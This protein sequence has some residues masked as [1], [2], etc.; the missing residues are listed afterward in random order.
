MAT[1]RKLPSGKYQ[2]IVRVV[3][4]PPVS[5]TFYTIRE[6]STWARHTEGSIRAG[7]YHD[8]S[9]NISI[10]DLL[11]EYLASIEHLATHSKDKYIVPM[12][13]LHFKHQTI[14][15]IKPSH[16]RSYMDIQKASGYAPGTIRKNT[17]LLSRAL[18]YACKDLDI[19]FKNPMAHIRL[20]STKPMK[21]RRAITPEEEVRILAA[22]SDQMKDITIVAIETGLRRSEITKMKPE[23][24]DHQNHTLLVPDTKNGHP[25]TVPLTDRAYEV[26]E[27]FTGWTLGN[28]SL[29]RYFTLTARAVGI[30]DISFHCCRH[31]CATRLCSILTPIEVM[32]VL[33]HRHAS[34][35]LIYAHADTG[36]I[37]NKL[38]ALSSALK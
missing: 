5:R 3:G 22:S 19:E 7:A 28:H 37:A 1:R 34:M 38:K 31:T 18:T 30:H 13:S 23:H 29:T 25:R 10:P 36:T 27:N 4:H 32:R 14:H 11:V 12:L 9:V 33:G 15:T 35:L 20:P 21:P 2:F 6:G 16:I 24:I 8:E 26:I 17:A